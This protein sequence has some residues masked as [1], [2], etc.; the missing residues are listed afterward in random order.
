MIRE[1]P[2][3]EVDGVG[4][5]FWGREV[6]KAASFSAWGGRI[7][8]LMGRNGVGKTTLLRVAVGRVR[9][10]WGRVLFEGAFVGRPN[11]AHL[12]K[13]GLMYSSQE[14]RLTDLFSVRD[15]VRAFCHVYGGQKLSPLVAESL[16]LEGLLDQ[17]PHQL[18]GGER[19]RVALGLALIRRPRCLLMDEPFAGVAPVDRPLVARGLLSLKAEGVAVVISGHDVED[20]F[21]VSDEVIWVV[22]GTTHWLGTPDQAS[23]HHDFRM[24][25]LGPRRR[26][27][28]PENMDAPA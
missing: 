21:D 6:L 20:L 16:R 7:T 13:Q 3:L 2:L 28:S 14:S 12:A 9:P 25:Y 24:S 19:K 22:A 1:R 5:S 8:T 17:R 10:Q 4:V 11:L 15:H 27:A 23:E 26:V 18:S